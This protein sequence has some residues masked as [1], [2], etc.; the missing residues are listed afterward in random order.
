VFHS[1]PPA[2]TAPQ[3]R[4]PL[5]IRLGSRLRPHLDQMMAPFSIVGND[6]VLDDRHF[7]WAAA[8]RAHWRAIRKEALAVTRNP[9]A[10]PT[11]SSISP[12][13]QRIGADQGWRSF[14]LIG[15]GARIERNIAR[16]P[17]TAG[18]LARIPGL[19]SGF[20]SVLRPGTHIPRHTGV[21][22]GLVTCHLGLVVPPGPLRMKVDERELRWREGETLF[23]DDTY[24]HEV[25]N[26]TPG[27]RIVLLVQVER[28]L[29]QPGKA[30]ARA[31][32]GGI[33]RSAFVQ[34]AVANID[35]WEDSLRQIEA[36]GQRRP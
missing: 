15:Y 26:D 22:K 27:T 6:P 31:F 3:T 34:D 35:R 16:C 12:D 29:R 33:R 4:R 18:L 13:H 30:I 21:T 14:F 24:P 32:L 10:V 17:V 11:L 36:M 9:E 20:F 1:P 19:N 28:P 23:F 2:A 8:L 25:W 5:S 7:P